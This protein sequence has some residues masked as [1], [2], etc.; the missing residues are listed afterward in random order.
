V[1]LAFSTCWN[2]GRHS[3]GEEM[4]EEISSLGFDHVELGHGIR[5]PLWEGIERFL[6]DHP[7]SVTSLHNFCP[8]PAEIQ[9]AAP[10]CYECTAV[11]TEE[12]DR[13][14]SHTLRTIDFAQKLGVR[15]V[16]MHLGSV[17]M[18]RYTERLFELIDSGRYLDRSYVAT[19]IKAIRKREANSAYDLIVEWLKP[20]LDHAAAAGVVLGIEN[21]IR[22]ETCPSE[23]EFRLL[24]ANIDSIGYWHDFGHAQIRHNLTF[25]DH[26]EW[27][28]E[29]SSHLIGCHVH[30]VLFPYSDHQAPFSGMIDFAGLLA[31]IP[32]TVPLVWELSSR[33][34]RE[35]IVSALSRWKQEL[36]S[37][38]S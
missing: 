20:V 18:P 31:S 19:K 23:R 16:I 35:E 3:R 11:R 17:Q 1:P 7:M 14:R 25:I 24:F 36:A 8:L 4:L 15:Y 21:R 13:A 28:S 6:A 9:G 2:S 33:A 32:S 30:D 37:L 10:D 38:N 12:R 26:A 5:I 29:M 22:I 34:S 27:L